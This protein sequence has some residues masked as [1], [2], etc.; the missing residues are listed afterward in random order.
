LSS[1]ESVRADKK[2][3][4]AVQKAFAQIEAGKFD[5]ALKSA[6]K[7][8]RD[9][10]KPDA[11]VASSRIL[12]RVG[13]LEDALMRARASVEASAAAAPA[14]RGRALE[15]LAALELRIGTGKDA[16]AHAQEAAKLDPAATATLA[17]AQ[18]RVGDPQALETAARLVK[19]SP[20][21]GLAHDAHGVALA[22]GGQLEE[23]EKA[24]RRA[25]ELLP[26]HYEVRWHLAAALVDAGKGAEAETAAREA[27]AADRNQGEAYT[28]LAL[29]ILLKNPKGFTPAVAEAQQGVMLTPRSVYTQ[30][31]LGRVFEADQNWPAAAAAYESA[32]EADPGF[33]KAQLALIGAQAEAGQLDAA[34]ASA[35]ALTEARPNDPHAHLLYGRVLTRKGDHAKALQPLTRATQLAPQDAEVHVA[36]AQTH[37]AERAYAKGIA[38]YKRAVELQPK[39]TRYRIA[40]GRAY[41]QAGQTGQAIEELKRVAATPGYREAEA[42]I[43]LGWAY[44][45]GATRRSPESI[46]NYRRALELEPK[47]GVAMLGLGRVL[48]ASR[49]CGEANSVLES[50]MQL[51][52]RSTGEAQVLLAACHY[53]VAVASKSGD[54]SRAKAALAKARNILGGRDPRVTKLEALIQRA[55]AK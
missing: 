44:A 8:G 53:D 25:V 3:D 11:L 31:G 45:N 35:R 13:K 1:A 7:L 51:D 22:A 9:A 55:E 52:S 41:A 18:A 32:R 4:E 26:R 14:V 46:M 21:S 17:R 2:T 48:A 28:S 39:N 47:N 38:N 30:Y 15:N 23:A 19:G 36:V 42:Y 12:A 6:E 16:L 40:L 10:K 50:A 34:A 54:M 24:L 29:A 33:T 37:L 49:N 43:E 5:D 27:I 20:D